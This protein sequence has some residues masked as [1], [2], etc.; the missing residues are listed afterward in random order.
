M[1]AQPFIDR[2]L[3]LRLKR[4]NQN[5][6][7]SLTCRIIAKKQETAKIL[8]GFTKNRHYHID[9]TGFTATKFTFPL[10]KARPSPE[11]PGNLGSKT[12]MQLRFHRIVLLVAQIALALH[13]KHDAKHLVLDQ[14]CQ[15]FRSNNCFL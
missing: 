15:F 2:V 8:L 14:H 10:L 5:F 4:K 13:P 1:T 11:W 7:K 12:Q 6:C 3:K 9:V